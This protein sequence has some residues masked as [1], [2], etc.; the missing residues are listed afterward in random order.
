MEELAGVPLEVDALLEVGVPEEGTAPNY[1]ARLEKVEGE[2]LHVEWPANAKCRAVLWPDQPIFLIF[3]RNEIVF[4][5]NG[6]VRELVLQ[7][8]A[9]IVIQPSGALRR[10]QRRQYCRV[11]T[12][13]P[14]QLSG[15]V[16]PAE[17]PPEDPGKPLNLITHTVDISGSGFAIHHGAPIPVNQILQVRINLEPDQPPLK[18]EVQVV[19]CNPLKTFGEHPLY[20][21]AMTYASISESQRSAIIRYVFDIQRSTLGE[22]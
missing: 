14:L 15:V 19:Q 11:R 20:C 16:R 21:I 1:F 10:T 13:I 6:W 9:R 17:A 7:P 3:I 5:V 4:Q 18:F 2:F 12:L 22:P 8:A